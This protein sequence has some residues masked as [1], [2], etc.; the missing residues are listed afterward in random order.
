MKSPSALGLPYSDWRTGQ[1]LAIRTALHSKKQHVMLNAPTGAGKSLIAAAL[2][3]LD[4]VSRTLTLTATNALLTQY[5]NLF[6]HLTPIKGAGNY[7]CLAARDELSRFFRLTKR[8][9]TIVGCDDGP[10][11]SQVPCSL[12]E[13]GCLYFDAVRAAMSSRSP[14]TNYAYWLAMRRYANG[15]GP[16]DRLIV[17]EAHSLPDELMKAHRIEIGRHELQGFYGKTIDSWKQWAALKYRSHTEGVSDTQDNRV[18]YQKAKERY[19]KLR[20]IDDTWAFDRTS[21]GVT[22]EPTV[23]RLLFP[24]LADS[25]TSMVYMSATI[26]PA[27]LELL[28]V[29]P[30]DVEYLSLPSTF[31]LDRRPIYL[32]KT[33]RVQHNMSAD[34]RSYWLNRHDQVIRHRL[35][36]KGIIHAGS[37]DRQQE[38][39][40]AS[41]YKQFMLTPRGDALVDA[42]AQFR[43]MKPPAILVSPSIEQGFDFPYTD[44]EYIIVSKMPFPDTRSNI[45]KARIRATPLYRDYSTII[46]VQQAVGRGMRADDDQCETFILDD[47]ARWFLDKHADLCSDSFLSAVVRVQ[48]IPHPLPRLDRAAA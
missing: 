4:T 1:R 16:A 43:T 44:C 11:R 10:C 29:S 42:V 3:R 19:S 6:P 27:M 25:A 21:Y 2:T 36:R 33:S 32:V 38:I 22:F 31:P 39:Y 5:T 48:K 17:D 40:R 18:R 23:P 35:D 37:Y 7:E 41:K 14:L 34:A 13:D 45:M 8:S 30:D 20:D 24:L 9:S 46:R 26:T 47:H 12:R 15:L 28:D